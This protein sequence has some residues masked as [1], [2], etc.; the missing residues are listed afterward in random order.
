[1]TDIRSD[2]KQTSTSIT[3]SQNNAS[4]IPQSLKK[5]SEIP[6]RLAQIN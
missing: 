3:N 4:Y 1:M 2:K 5:G 6:K